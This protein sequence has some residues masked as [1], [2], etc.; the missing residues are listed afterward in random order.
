M[1]WPVMAGWVLM[2]VA[3]ASSGEKVPGVAGSRRSEP[4][5]RA[6]GWP[7]LSRRGS[8]LSCGR[9]AGECCVHP[10]K[11]TPSACDFMVAEKAKVLVTAG[12]FGAPADGTAARLSRTSSDSSFQEAEEDRHRDAPG[13][14]SSQN[15]L[16]G[17][18]S[19]PV[20]R[21]QSLSPSPS[22]CCFPALGSE[23]PKTDCDQ[24]CESS[25]ARF[26]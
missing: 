3:T 18:V 26:R 11:K 17:A 7:V 2:P 4:V 16:W 23:E 20:Q 22:A 15:C 1:Q 24:G 13:V 12:G 6:Q 19:R 5:R 21:P 14:P 25:Y 9:L 8:E 10:E